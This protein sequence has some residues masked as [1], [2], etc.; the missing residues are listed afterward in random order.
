MCFLNSAQ[1]D[2]VR[3]LVIRIYK[4]NYEVWNSDFKVFNIHAS[5]Q[6]SINFSKK[7]SKRDALYIRPK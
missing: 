3:F 1:N 6:G 7:T 2:S 4:Y 5:L